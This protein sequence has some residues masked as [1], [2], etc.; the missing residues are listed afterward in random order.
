MPTKAQLIE[1]LQRTLKDA[2][3][4]STAAENAGR[5][6]TPTESAQLET[7][8]GQAKHLQTQIKQAKGDEAVRAAIESLSDGFSMNGAPVAG[9][10]T[11]A[12]KPAWVTKDRQARDDWAKSV[13]DI[14]S[15][16][17]IGDGRKSFISGDY[18]VAEP[19][20][21]EIDRLPEYPRRVVDVLVNRRTI[22][23]GNTFTWLV[24]T[25]RNN[26]AAPVADNAQK[27]TTDLQ[28][29]EEEGRCQVI[30]HI[31][32][33]APQRHL[34]DYQQ[35]NT[36]IS[37]E[38]YSGLLNALEDQVINGSGT[39]P[40]LRGLL[41]TSGIL[42]QPW[43]TD[44]L[45][46]LRKASTALELGEVTPNALLMNPTDAE[47]LDLLD[48][49]NARFYY[50]GPKQQIS[51]GPVWSTP[52]VKSTAIPAGTA[53]LADWNYA[54]LVIRE[55]ANMAFDTSGVLFQKN[56]FIARCEGRYGF[57]CM[58]PSAFVQIETSNL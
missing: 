39:D 36:F 48:D 35:L 53:I 41:N 38:M 32:N 6:L 54:E 45:T 12:A 17:A 27:P 50:D 47:G 14:V 58:R 10:S 13:T 46:T 22:R 18:E 3:S 56:Q 43:T 49:A 23:Q 55:D 25:L 24:Q 4:L 20:S 29:G 51:S 30:A 34:A 21:R 33:P 40:N 57:A 11:K 2:R 42:V 19:L 9:G 44:L 28:F 16:N 15:K 7:Y 5:D 31:T 37:D 1:D 52:L 8:L 26:N